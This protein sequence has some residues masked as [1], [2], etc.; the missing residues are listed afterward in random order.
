LGSSCRTTTAARAAF[1]AAF[2]TMRFAVCTN[3]SWTSERKK[4]NTGRNAI[5][6]ST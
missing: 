5:K 2:F 4:K 1:T 3:M 6:N